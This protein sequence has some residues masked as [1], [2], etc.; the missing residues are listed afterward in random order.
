MTT[1]AGDDTD[2]IKDENTG[3]TITF[4]ETAASTGGDRVVMRLDLAPGTVVG[5]HAH[6]IAETFERLEG[7]VQL[8]VDGRRVD[9]GTGPA[10]VPG[11]H[12]HGLRNAS[13]RPAS[14]R[15]TGTPGVEAEFG[16]RVK[17]QLSRDGYIPV[18][19]GGPPKRPLVGAVVIHR[20][21]L[22]FPPLPR[23]LFRS[24]VAMAAALGRWRGA[25]RFLVDSY[26]DY[27][28]Y[29]EALGAQGR[30]SPN[31]EPS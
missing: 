19:G 10:T 18:P 15:V 29:L 24:L 20:G 16:L 23:F 8:E 2:T 25:E 21:V 11:G 12:L 3:E 27:A 13:S 14:L 7:E 5:L 6:P 31:S 22:Y 30:K 28:R 1:R 26:P 9:L 17:F 4:L